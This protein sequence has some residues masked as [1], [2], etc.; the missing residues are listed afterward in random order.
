MSRAV[1]DV[2]PDEEYVMGHIPGAISLLL[3]QLADGILE[4]EAA[5]LPVESVE[6]A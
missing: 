4:W 6:V 2:R 1:I 3:D 5:A